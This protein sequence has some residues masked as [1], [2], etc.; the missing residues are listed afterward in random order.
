MITTS[1]VTASSP[2]WRASFVFPFL[3]KEPWLETGPGRL[4]FSATPTGSLIADIF[5]ILEQLKDEAVFVRDAQELQEYLLRFPGIV[6]VLVDA[7]RAV[8]EHFPEAKL[9]LG[10]Y[11]DPEIED[12]YPFLC[13]RLKKYDENFMECL[14]AAEAEFIGRLTDTEG[15]LQLTT[16]FKDP[17]MENAF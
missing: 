14:E 4:I 1:A 3:L 6:D 16:D 9:L 8:K 13:V 15:W 12:R 5:R 11:R 7:V 17:E 10:V 2:T